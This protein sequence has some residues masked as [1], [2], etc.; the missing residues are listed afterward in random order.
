MRKPCAEPYADPA[1]GRFLIWRGVILTPAKVRPRNQAGQALSGELTKARAD[2]V[3]ARTKALP[4]RPTSR[5][6]DLVRLAFR[7]LSVIYA[8]WSDPPSGDDRQGAGVRAARA[9]TAAARVTFLVQRLEPYGFVLAARGQYFRIATLSLPSLGK[10]RRSRCTLA[11]HHLWRTRDCPESPL[12]RGDD[13][14]YS[15]VSLR[16]VGRR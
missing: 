10:A 3:L 15:C 2:E 1:G 9:G 4:I 16:G 14:I 11:N 6:A 8:R 7:D 13:D 12:H 5:A